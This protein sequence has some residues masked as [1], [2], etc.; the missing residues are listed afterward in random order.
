MTRC[1]DDRDEIILGDWRKQSLH[2]IWN[3]EGYKEIWRLHASGNYYD[4]EMCR[5][6]YLPVSACT[7]PDRA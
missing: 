7:P 5:K 6:C 1:V 2:S 4:M 3:S